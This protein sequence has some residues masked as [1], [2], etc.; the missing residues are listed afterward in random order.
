MQIEIQKRDTGKE[1]MEKALAFTGTAETESLHMNIMA[2]YGTMTKEFKLA[3]PANRHED[4]TICA[5]A[6]PK[7]SREELDEVFV[8]TLEITRHTPKAYYDDKDVCSP[9][10]FFA[11]KSDTCREVSLKILDYFIDILAL[12]EAVD[13][14]TKHLEGMDRVE[15]VHKLLFEDSDQG[16]S[17]YSIIAVPPRS[18]NY[19]SSNKKKSN[20]KF[21]P[22]DL[23]IEDFAEKSG[24]DD[25]KLKLRFAER[26]E[27]DLGILGAKGHQ[28]HGL[29]AAAVT[30]DD[31]FDKFRTEELLVDDNQVYCRNCKEHKDAYKKMDVYKLPNILII[32]L[33]RFNRGSRGSSYGMSYG[34]G[35]ASGASKNS[36]LIDFPLEG[37]DMEK[38]VLDPSSGEQTVYDLYGIS[39]H[40]GSLYGGH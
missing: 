15:A 14:E 16:K 35:M 8:F 21:E 5:Y 20:V 1:I 27:V 7:L 3:D 39:N 26:A 17:L 11:R 4:A 37:L 38:Y 6:Y 32:Q 2:R 19:Y 10:T 40:M 13:D 18:V 33:K 34:M 25:L 36:D 28:K 30:L 22:N 23:S 24:S 29:R 9:M 31:C 12:P